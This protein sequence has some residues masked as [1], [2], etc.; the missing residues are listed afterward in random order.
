VDYVRVYQV[1]I[2]KIMKALNFRINVPVTILLL[3]AITL[4]ETI[5]S[6]ESSKISSSQYLFPDF[7]MS[8]IQMKS[9]QDQ[10]VP[11]NYNTL[12][13]KMVYQ[14]GSDLL[15]L[16]NTDMVDTVFLQDSKFVPADNSFHEV[17]L[18][19]PVSFFI[20]HKGKLIPPGTPAGYG[21]TSQTSATSVKSSIQTPQGYY[22][23]KLP[24]DYTV[25]QDDIYWI[26]KGGK[27]YSFVNERQFLKLI[28]DEISDIKQFIKLNNIKFAKIPDVVKLL[29]YYNQ[30][31]RN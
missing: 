2:D 19:A 18:V 3:L 7:K 26:R 27:Y 20:Q 23:L 11:V 1:V 28:P 6:Q 8:K 30:I 16:V 31:V 17:M 13:E 22:N 5:K 10:M 25:R 21:G 9:G 29:K 15:D 24:D 14:K 4:S 12:S